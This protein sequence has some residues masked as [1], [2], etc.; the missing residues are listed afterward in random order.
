M[1]QCNRLGKTTTGGRDVAC[2]ANGRLWDASYDDTSALPFRWVF[3]SIFRYPFR[4]PCIALQ[5][6]KKVGNG[7]HS[8][9][10]QEKTSGRAKAGNCCRVRRKR[11]TSRIV[12]IRT[13]GRGVVS[14]IKARDLLQLLLLVVRMEASVLMTL[15]GMRAADSMPARTRVKYGTPRIRP[16]SARAKTD[17]NCGR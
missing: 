12:K 15:G 6:C 17:E 7:L 10:E 4:Y 1:L 9:L 8:T 5:R 16:L 11:A 3:L 13:F 14:D 2:G